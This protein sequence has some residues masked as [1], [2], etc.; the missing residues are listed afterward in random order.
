MARFAI[1]VALLAM[2]AGAQTA[3]RPEPMEI[4]NANVWE[5]RLDE[6]QVLH[7][8]AEQVKAAVRFT[9]SYDFV[10]D[11]VVS[12][13]G[14]V[15]SATP[16]KNW[17]EMPDDAKR[18]E[19]LAIVRAR[20]YKPWLVDG[21][22]VRAKVQDYVMV[23]PPERRGPEV[24]FPTQVDRTTLEMSLQRTHCYGSCPAY[25]VSVEGNGTVRWDGE[26]SWSSR[27]PGHH[28]GHVSAKAVTDLLDQFRAADFLSALPHYHSNWT[29]NPTQTLTL[30]MG[31]KTWTVVDYDGLKDGLPM[32]VRELEGE[33]DKA[34]GTDVWLKGGPGLAAALKAENWNFGAATADNMLLYISSLGNRELVEQFLMAKAPVAE[35]IGVAGLPLCAASGSGDLDLVKRMLEQVKKLLAGVADACLASAAGSGSL[36]MVDLWVGKG[37]D[38]TVRS[39]PWGD[40]KTPATARAL[41]K[42]GLQWECG[43]GAASAGPEG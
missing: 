29:D 2:V 43:G 41:G 16:V 21:V 4:K 9:G 6:E 24:A 12:E 32:A 20:R 30:R 11:L 36:A 14:L 3:Q 8:T 17:S 25:T 19:A 22:P 27:V 5:H 28:V 23:Y 35:K 42:R 26:D 13:N 39:A 37:G 10:F 1:G 18:D 33:I 34:A 38:P 40:E 31:E 7:L 15:E